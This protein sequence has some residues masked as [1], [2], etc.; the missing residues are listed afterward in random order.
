[1]KL[2]SNID[3]V[4]GF[5]RIG[6]ALPSKGGGKILQNPSRWVPERALESPE[7]RV[8]IIDRQKL[9]RLV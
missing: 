2:L 5:S 8:I 4:T 9:L 1:M 7:V 3:G 6:L